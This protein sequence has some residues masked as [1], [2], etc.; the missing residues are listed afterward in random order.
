[1]LCPYPMHGWA[2]MG[3]HE[4]NGGREAAGIGMAGEMIAC[5]PVAIGEP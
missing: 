4:K 2:E 1:M 3:H 5:L